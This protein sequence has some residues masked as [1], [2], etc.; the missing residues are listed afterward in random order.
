MMNRKDS[1]LAEKS[2][3]LEEVMGQS[4]MS[5]KNPVNKPFRVGTGN[6]VWLVKYRVLIKVL[7]CLISTQG[8]QSFR[9]WKQSSSE[10]P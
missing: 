6:R 4:Y 5:G 3:N 8:D 7:S 2:R 9:D 10:R 1:N